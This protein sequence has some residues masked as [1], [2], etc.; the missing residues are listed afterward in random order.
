MWNKIFLF[1]YCFSSKGNRENKI[2]NKVN[3]KRA[4]INQAKVQKKIQILKF[5]VS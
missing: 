4:K 2:K 1:K 5:D 3:K